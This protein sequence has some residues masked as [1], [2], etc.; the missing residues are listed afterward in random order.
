M[1]YYRNI[2]TTEKSALLMRSLLRTQLKTGN[3]W[4]KCNILTR[5]GKHW[6]R[7]I[8][9]RKWSKIQL[10]VLFSIFF[11]SPFISYFHCF[12]LSLLHSVSVCVSRRVCL[13]NHSSV[14]LLFLNV[15]AFFLQYKCSPNFL[16]SFSFF[17][18]AASSFF[19]ILSCFF[20]PSYHLIF[21]L[22]LLAESFLL[23]APVFF[24]GNV[25][26][27]SSCD[28]FFQVYFTL[29]DFISFLCIVN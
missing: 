15:I 5:H 8:R 17:I 24:F 2:L 11:S 26:Y 19:L 20:F 22:Y 21:F 28:F 23:L 27:S 6:W 7:S 10:T 18:S 9:Q 25:L 16:V 4:L 12:H 3:R 13:S 14:L 1:K 29:V